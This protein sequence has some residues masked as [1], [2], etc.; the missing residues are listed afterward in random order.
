MDMLLDKIFEGAYAPAQEQ[1]S[2]TYFKL[3]NK[4]E[5]Y[6][7][8]L[9]KKMGKQFVTEYTYVCE[10]AS[11]QLQKEAFRA[12]VRFGFQLRKELSESED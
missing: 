2:E 5:V 9:V 3:M 1:P 10:D 8:Q 7:D 12:G 11:F 4:T 6:S